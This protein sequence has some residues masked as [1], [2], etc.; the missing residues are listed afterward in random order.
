MITPLGLL[1]LLLPA[2][3]MALGLT[4][5]ELAAWSGYS[6]A[7]LVLLMVGDHLLSHH[8]AIFTAA[9]H[10]PAKLSVG[11]ENRVT[12][13]VRSRS[14]LLMRL[15]VKDDPPPA[16]RTPQRQHR[17]R[18]PPFAT[19]HVIYHTTP[20][21]RGDFRFG[22]LHFRGLSL[23][24]LSYWQQTVRADQ[25]VAVYPNMAELA[26]YEQLA[27]SG[28][29][30]Q[31]GYRPYRRLGL[32][33]EFESLRDYLPDDEYRSIDWK[34]TARRRRPITRQYEAERSQSLM[35]MID[36]GRMMAGTAGQM[37]K[38]DYAVNAALM[39]AHVAAERDDRVGLLAFADS[40]QQFLP[41]GKGQAQVGRLAEALYAL[42]P[43]LLEPDYSLAF[44][45]LFSR[46]RKRS[47][48]ICFTD[49]IDRDASARLL[50][51][52]ASLF[53]RH[54]PLLIAIRDPDLQAAAAQYPRD[55]FAAY[56]KAAAV[57]AVA[58]RRTALAALGRGGVLVLDATPEELTVATVNR[59]LQIKDTHAL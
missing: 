52:M 8:L 6:A 28:R 4:R 12:V 37:S 36:S 24:G 41:P 34:A 53:P 55:P 33:T 45:T 26:R 51:G 54:L 40:V 20:T 14:P 13:T 19:R 32:G 22:H 17:L 10:A 11:V 9:R 30:S 43:Q 49:L 2:G 23:L 5:P 29:L 1:V 46:S 48:V 57:A 58:D 31:A 27:R 21:E 3:I 35:L 42:E 16:F 44:S 56:E 38:L 7:A 59:Y 15:V 50:S 39:L 47:L 25:Q 18:L